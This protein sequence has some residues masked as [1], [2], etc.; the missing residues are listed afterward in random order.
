MSRKKG[1]I[2][3]YRSYDLHPNFPVML[4][5]DDVWRI[6]DIPS[7]RL[8]F[9]NCLEIGLCES[10][11][12]TIR[13]MT[14]EAT[15]H[16]G[17]VTF[18]GL[19]IPHTTFSTKGTASKWSYLFVDVEELLSRFFP[20]DTMYDQ[21]LLQGILLNH[22]AIMPGKLYP[23][24]YQLI[25][26]MIRL[27]KKQDK[28]YQIV[29]R[30]MMIAFVTEIM[31]IFARE[32]S[33]KD[34]LKQK[35]FSIAPALD[36]IRTN[37]KSAFSIDTLADVCNIS[38]T[39]FRRLFS[40]IMGVSPL[41]YII[42]FRVSKASRLLCTTEMT[43]MEISLESGFSSISSFNRHFQS[44]KGVT[45]T[46]WRKNTSVLQNDRQIFKYKGWLVPPKTVL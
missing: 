1:T 21:E 7:S 12:G 44:I 18:I 23:D 29:V 2:I 46:Q 13:T 15:F 6:S 42:Q 4:L 9:H 3:E 8:H 14:G 28:N 22:F 37:Y 34:D 27:M 16:E 31:N 11:S 32:G 39:H 41:E 17:D 20:I 38:S 35:T 45:P 25:T 26:Y 24:I 30:G 36:Y 33:K 19:D 5:C 40:S 43:V 10:D